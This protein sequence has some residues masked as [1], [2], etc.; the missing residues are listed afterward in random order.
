MPP[1]VMTVISVRSRTHINKHHALFAHNI[2]ILSQGRCQ[3]LL[4]NKNIVGIVGRMRDQV[5]NKL[6]FP[7]PSH[8]MVQ[9]DKNCYFS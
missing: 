8:L 2:Y 1:M 5:K 3:R 4:N 6:F 9:Q 7:L